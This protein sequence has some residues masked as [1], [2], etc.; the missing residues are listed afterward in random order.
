M[1]RMQADLGGTGG[2]LVIDDEA[3]VRS[4]AKSTLEHFGYSVFEAD[5]GARG[6]ELFRQLQDDIALVLLDLTMPEMGGEEA[7]D[8]LRQ[9]QPDIPVILSSGYDEAEATRRFAGKNVNGFLKKPYTAE[10][11]ADRV[12]SVLAAGSRRM[13]A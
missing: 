8:I 7:F 9:I 6:V 3:L 11:L 12:K 4:I 2:I 1:A 10:T 13:R 5:D